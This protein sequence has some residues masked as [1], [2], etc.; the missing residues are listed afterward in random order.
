MNALTKFFSRPGAAA[1]ATGA[2]V[3]L[4]L[5]AWRA[6]SEADASSVSFAGREL[7]MACSFREHFGVPCPNCGMT[8][9]VLMSLHG[10][11]SGAFSLNPTG[12]LLVL[13]T[14]LF[15]AAM[16]LLMYLQRRRSPSEVER[17]RRAVKLGAVAY[18][19]SVF[20]VM[21]AHWFRQMT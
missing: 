3:A 15:A 12:P 6:L 13:G 4:Q 18:G 21:L 8:R 2:L 5:A 1:G 7:D 11:V 17:V 16:F 9:S 19:V 14:V 20:A 10:D